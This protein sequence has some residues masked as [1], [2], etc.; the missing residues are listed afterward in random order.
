MCNIYEII[1]NLN[2]WLK[3]HSFNSSNIL[4]NLI[5]QISNKK[6]SQTAEQNKIIEQLRFQILKMEGELL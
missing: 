4:N 6:R 2:E 1:N 3:E 5:N